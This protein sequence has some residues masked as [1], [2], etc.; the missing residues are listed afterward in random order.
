MIRVS[1]FK[2]HGPSEGLDECFIEY[3]GL[4]WKFKSAKNLHFFQ[5]GPTKYVSQYGGYWAFGLSNGYEVKPKM[6]AYLN[7]QKL[8]ARSVDGSVAEKIKMADQ[9]WPA[10]K[11]STPNS[12]NRHWIFLKYRILK[13]IGYDSLK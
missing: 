6:D 1:Y 2:D 3:K 13:I 10:V 4:R 8:C 11:S 9:K 5:Q 12:T 7:F